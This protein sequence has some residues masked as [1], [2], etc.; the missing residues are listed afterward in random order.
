MLAD[1]VAIVRK[2]YE[3]SV[4]RAVLLYHATRRYDECPEQE[5]SVEIRSDLDKGAELREVEIMR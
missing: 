2:M 3:S 1:E 5:E 4:D